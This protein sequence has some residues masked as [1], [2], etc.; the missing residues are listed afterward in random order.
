MILM[1]KL[2]LFFVIKKERNDYMLVL[3][4]FFGFFDN[5]V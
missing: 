3:D 4:I 2:D 1:I 5:N